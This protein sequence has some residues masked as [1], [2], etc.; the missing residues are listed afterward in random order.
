MAE[1]EKEP[2]YIDCAI[3][4]RRVPRTSPNRKYCRAC[5]DKMHRS[6]RKRRGLSD[7]CLNNWRDLRGKSLARVDAEAKAF[8]LSYGQYTAA[9]Y[10]GGIDTLLRSRGFNDPGGVLKGLRIR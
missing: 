9:V 1:K 3:C 8:G 7:Q 6:G 4:G 10:S 2:Q 5:A